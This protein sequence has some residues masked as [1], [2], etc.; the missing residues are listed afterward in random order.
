MESPKYQPAQKP[1]VDPTD[2]NKDEKTKGNVAEPIGDNENNSKGNSV[3]EPPKPI[4]AEPTSPPA[5]K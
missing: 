2:R 5:Q 3:N 1:V 4:V